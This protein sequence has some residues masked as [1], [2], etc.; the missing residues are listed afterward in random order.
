MGADPCAITWENRGLHT[1][2]RR[3][4]R[5]R[6]RRPL[7][8]LISLFLLS[9]C[10][11]RRRLATTTTT[12]AQPLFFILLSLCLKKLVVVV[13]AAA[14]AAILQCPPDVGSRHTFS[15]CRCVQCSSNQR[16]AT[17]LHNDDD[18]TT[19]RDEATARM[20]QI[21]SCRYAP[22]PKM[23]T[24]ATRLDNRHTHTHTVDWLKEEEEENKRKI[25]FW[26]AKGSLA[27]RCVVYRSR[28]L[29]PSLFFCEV[30]IRESLFFSLAVVCDWYLSPWR[31]TTTTT[32]RSMCRGGEEEQ[33][34]V[35]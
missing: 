33:E 5:R 8:Y 4:R 6:R 27:S 18:S 7:A 14:A 25:S 19:R 11:R 1:H 35:V 26:H 34:E 12:T 22:R 30:E 28:R 24:H 31:D 23:D 32:K 16:G 3:R 29:R 20:K 21:C 13:A 9:H 17:T 10:R 2:R 15:W